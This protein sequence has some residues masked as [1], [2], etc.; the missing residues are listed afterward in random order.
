M[1][2]FALLE[3]VI[4]LLIISLGLLTSTGMQLFALRYNQES[5]FHSLASVQLLSMTERLRAN[6]SEANRRVE[7]NRWNQLNAQLLPQGEGSYQCQN[8]YCEVKIKWQM[9][10]VHS[11]SMSAY[12]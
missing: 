4:A 3:V 5:Y 9:H 12:L 11:L 8:N 6:I 10:L 1:T 7:L 2:G